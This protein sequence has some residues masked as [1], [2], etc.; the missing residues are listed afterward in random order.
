MKKHTKLNSRISKVSPIDNIPIFTKNP[1]PRNLIYTVNSSSHASPGFSRCR[2]PSPRP[3][4]KRSLAVF[5]ISCDDLKIE[6]FNIILSTV[7]IHVRPLM[8]YYRLVWFTMASIESIH[9]VRMYIV[10]VVEYKLVE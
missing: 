9:T 3:R 7:T 8:S 2:R 5:L 6:S 4:E 1:P 10:G